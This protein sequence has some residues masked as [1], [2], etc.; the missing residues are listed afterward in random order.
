[1][2]WVHPALGTP[3]ARAELSVGTK[4]TQLWRQ[5]FA[6]ELLFLCA[7]L[8]FP[9]L[10]RAMWGKILQGYVYGNNSISVLG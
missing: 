1:M 3:M 2:C 10:H 9:A 8:H 4:K 5:F 7:L 6:V